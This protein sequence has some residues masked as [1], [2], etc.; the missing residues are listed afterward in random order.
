M[1]FFGVTRLEHPKGVKDEVKQARWAQSRPGSGVGGVRG[2][3][4][5]G[6][7]SRVWGPGSMVRQNLKKWERGA[8]YNTMINTR[9]PDKVKNGAPSN[10]PKI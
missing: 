2:S 5:E 1:Q 3:L 9:A 7:G 10:C 4:V 8:C 6:R